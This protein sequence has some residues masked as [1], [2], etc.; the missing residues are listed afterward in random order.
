MIT[1]FVWIIFSSV[2]YSVDTDLKG[3]FHTRQQ[4]S[5]PQLVLTQAGAMTSSVVRVCSVVSASMSCFFQSLRI[6]SRNMD[7]TIFVSRT[8]ISFLEYLI[9][10]AV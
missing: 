3:I 2:R 9:L 1:L 5:E 7:Y 10:I 8:C 4:S 6:D